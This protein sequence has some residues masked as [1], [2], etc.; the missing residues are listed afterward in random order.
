MAEKTEKKMVFLSK[1]VEKMLW[2]MVKEE[3]RAQC[4]TEFVQYVDCCKDHNVLTQIVACRPQFN[5]INDCLKKYPSQDVFNEKAGA[6]IRNINDF[7]TTID[8]SL[9]LKNSRTRIKPL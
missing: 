9:A 2:D 8:A 1:E 5:E 4:K 6:Y 7:K 3:A